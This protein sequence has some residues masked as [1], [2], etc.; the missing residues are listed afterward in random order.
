MKTVRH[1][2]RGF[3]LTELLVVIAVIA[4]LA[5]LLIPSV[6]HSKFKARVVT[7]TNNY[8]Q[9]TLASALYATDDP[10]GRLPS[11][12]LPTDSSQLVGFRNLVPWVIGMPML[13]EMEHQG[14]KPEMWYCPLRN[15]WRDDSAFF[16]GKFG[17]PL[18]TAA[19]LAKFFTDLQGSKYAFMDLNWWVPR[20]LEGSTLTYPDASLLRTR[21]TT[22]WPSRIDDVS[23]SMRPIVSD[24]LIGSKSTSGDGFASASGGHSF[25]G[26]TRNCNSGYGDGHV[27]TTSA[28][29]IKWQLQLSGSTESNYIFY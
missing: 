11:F 27:E 9:L 2:K 18:I 14:I 29:N 17:R 16:Q 4:V 10:K 15:R 21:V 3:T 19:D 5:A 8:K 6:L 22:S 25:G 7:C 28:S 26:K 12:E 23:I 13:T 24:W 20:K 1:L